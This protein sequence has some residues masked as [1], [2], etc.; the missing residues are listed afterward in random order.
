MYLILLRKTILVFV[1]T[2]VFMLV[3]VYQAIEM[4]RQFIYLT[5]KFLWPKN[6]VYKSLSSVIAFNI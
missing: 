6:N 5:S 3:K 2:I 1:L 4:I